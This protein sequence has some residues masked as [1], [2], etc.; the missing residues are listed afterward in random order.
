MD[1]F[2]LLLDSIKTE[3]QPET[4]EGKNASQSTLYSSL[5]SIIPITGR[6]NWHI[7]VECV[8]HGVTEWVPS[9]SYHAGGLWMWYRAGL[10]PRWGIF[11]EVSKR[12]YWFRPPMLY[13]IGRLNSW[14]NKSN[15]V[16]EGLLKEF[17]D[18]PDGFTTSLKSLYNKSLPVRIRMGGRNWSVTKEVRDRLKAKSFTIDDYKNETNQTTKRLM[19]MSESISIPDILS[20]MKLIS[21]DEEGEIY[22]DG[23][24]WNMQD[25]L[26][27][28]C[29]STG[30]HYLLGIPTKRVCKHGKF[31]PNHDGAWHVFEEDGNGAMCPVV[32]AGWTPA[33]ARRW[34]LGVEPSAVI[35]AEA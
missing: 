7:A 34:T 24:N 29:P 12:W 23:E 3:P 18:S 8:E 31:T 17:A 5:A 22:E 28:V 13:R 21:K 26:H 14:S 19:I 11:Y 9:V 2:Q 20:T 35:V 30:Q 4:N 25:F 6:R 10:H 33:E 32:G 1:S 27:V 15:G 16:I